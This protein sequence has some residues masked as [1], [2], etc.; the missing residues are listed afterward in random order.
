VS[1]LVSV[2]DVIADAVL[3]VDALPARG[4]DVLAHTGRL[5]AGGALNV[6]V[7]AA[8]AGLPGIYAGAHGTG[9]LGDLVRAALAAAGIAVLHPP[10]PDLDTGFTVALVDAGAE[11]TFVT[12][13][14]AE[15]RLGAAHLTATPVAAGDVVHVSGYGLAYPVTG[16]ALAA[17][18]PGVPSAALVVADPGPLGAD[19]PEAVLAAVRARA[20]WIS[21]NEAEALALTGAADAPAAARVLAAGWA[22][23]G[24]VVRLGAAGCLV[25]EPGGAPAPISAPSVAA[26]DASGAGDTHVGTFAAALVRGLSPAAAAE[27]ANAAAALSVTRPGPAAAPTSGEVD[28]ALGRTPPREAGR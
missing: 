26:V 15:A 10:E 18:L 6:L 24:A 11:R 23:A 12:A 1:R 2:G 3:A 19:A 25:A 16:P 28:A 22:R 7:A 21:A 4:G 20:D 5:A 14:G 8:R 13:L 17:W 27:R 9:P